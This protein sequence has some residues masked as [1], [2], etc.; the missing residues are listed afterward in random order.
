MQSR[1]IAPG[2]IRCQVLPGSLSQTPVIRIRQGLSRVA[3]GTVV[4]FFDVFTVPGTA[5]GGSI[6]VMADD[7]A[8]VYLNGVLLVAEASSAGNTY[9]TCSD[10]GIGC[11]HPEVIDLPA[12][13]LHSGSNTLEFAVAQRDGSSYGLDYAGYVTDPLATPEPVPLVLVGT[14]LLGMA[15]LLRRYLPNGKQ[16]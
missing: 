6:S 11:I 14:G 5:T 15:F 9:R 7:S 12:A 8:A 16:S 10:F 2:R 4:D 13:D 1:K 3:N